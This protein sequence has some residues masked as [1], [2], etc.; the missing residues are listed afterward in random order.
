MAEV[1]PLDKAH[2]MM[3]AGDATSRLRF[4]ERL[5]DTELFVVLDREP[6]GG[7]ISP[8]TFEIEAG[9]FVLAFD[10]EERLAGFT[11]RITPYA[12]M[13]GRV[14]MRMLG[15]RDIGLGLNLEVAPS[16]ILIPPDAVGWLNRTLARAPHRVTARIRSYAPPAGL[17]GR[18]ADALERKLA[19]CAGLVGAACLVGVVY[20]D[21]TPGY[22]LGFV[23][24]RRRGEAA[25]AKA[26]GE[27]LTFFDSDDGDWNGRLDIGFFAA[28]EPV[29]AKLTALGYCLELPGPDGQ[30]T[31]SR[32][33][34][35]RDPMRPP[36]LR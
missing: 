15:G 22:L 13:S 17:P 9:R 32:P 23:G 12:A 25:L 19:N 14:L 1:T 33:G 24:A 6:A 21:G 20:E 5:A 31:K 27:A 28:N 7:R 4:Y 18:L 2:A 30:N 34:P 29:A 35:G 8:E 36:I 3:Q 16:A 26:A 11:N 10:L